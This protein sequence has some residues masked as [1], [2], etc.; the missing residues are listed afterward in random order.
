MEPLKEEILDA[1]WD[2]VAIKK[3]AVPKEH[4]DRVLALKANPPV[5][6]KE[7][8][9]ADPYCDIMVYAGAN[10]FINR[11]VKDTNEEYDVPVHVVRIGECLIYGFCGEIFSQFGEIIRKESP[12][13]KMMLVEKGNTVLLIEH[14]LDMIKNADYLID[15]GPE[16]GREGGQIIACGTPDELK[17]SQQGFTAKF[18]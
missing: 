18:L 11:Y 3:R 7:I 2:T 1:K 16:G 12:T 13:D 5:F 17:K 4:C 15:M 8:T 10:G 9:I 14:N 6:G